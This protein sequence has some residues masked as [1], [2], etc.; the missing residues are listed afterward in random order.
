M[1]CMIFLTASIS[2][3]WLH[4]VTEGGLLDFADPTCTLDLSH[5]KGLGLSTPKYRGYV[6]PQHLN[7]QYHRIF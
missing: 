7:T 4:E 1:F 5:F 6:Y 2:Q 3:I